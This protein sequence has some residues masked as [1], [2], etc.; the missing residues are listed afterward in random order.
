MPF[1]QNYKSKDKVFYNLYQA[2]DYSK[3]T[4]HHVH[5]EFDKFGYEDKS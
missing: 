2:L 4:G 3:Q 5:N 1:H